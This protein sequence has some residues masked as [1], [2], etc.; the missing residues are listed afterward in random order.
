MFLSLPFCPFPWI[1]QYYFI[2]FFTLQEFGDRTNV[3]YHSWF[4]L[5]YLHNHWAPRR[6]YNPDWCS[7][8]YCT[9]I[10]APSIGDLQ[11]IEIANMNKDLIMSHLFTRMSARLNH[12][13]A[14]SLMLKLCT[15]DHKLTDTLQNCEICIYS[16]QTF[17]AGWCSTLNLTWIWW[18]EMFLCS[19][20]K[21]IINKG[22]RVN[23]TRI[24]ISLVDDSFMI[25]IWHVPHLSSSLPSRQSLC[26]LHTKAAGIHCLLSLHLNSF[27]PHSVTA[28]TS[29][30]QKVTTSMSKYEINNTAHHVYNIC[31][32][33]ATADQFI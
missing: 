7:H 33:Y 3:N 18:D 16:H 26:R 15:K 32:L 17:C 27:T 13:L 22:V 24:I 12:M 25:S 29:E 5:S 14:H 9:G 1:H 20:I 30:Q 4:H 21:I 6:I 31:T 23:K 8:R 11:H 19:Q 28:T 10:P 2:V